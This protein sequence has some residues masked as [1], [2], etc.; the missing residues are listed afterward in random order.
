MGEEVMLLG[1]IG[2]VLNAIFS[3]RIVYLG[4][5]EYLDSPVTAVRGGTFAFRIARP[6][7]SYF[8]TKRFSE[9]TFLTIEPV[10][11]E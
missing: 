10:S 3:L 5:A 9:R 1:S 2:L 6:V 8:V 11:R 4:C 7:R